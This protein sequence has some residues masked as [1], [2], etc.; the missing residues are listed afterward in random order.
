MTKKERKA[1]ERREF[2]EAGWTTYDKDMKELRLRIATFVLVL[3]ML[4]ISLVRVA[5]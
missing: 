3:A 2:I 5:K 4:I 1:K